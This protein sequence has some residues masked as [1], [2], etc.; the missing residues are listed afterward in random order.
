VPSDEEHDITN[1][2]HGIVVGIDGSNSSIAALN[3]AAHQAELTASVVKVVMTWEWPINF[4]WAFMPGSDYVPTADAQN[5]LDQVLES[6]RQEHPSVTFQS[7]LIEGH[8]AQVLVAASRRADLLVVGCR[9]HGE[10]AGMLLGSVSL[11][12]AIH[13]RCPV[14][15]VHNHS[16]EGQ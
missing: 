9:G 2:A 3:W 13:A 16:S 12:C 10:F 14:V 4:G 11:R 1:T 15:V 6:I 8:P 7:S 5:V